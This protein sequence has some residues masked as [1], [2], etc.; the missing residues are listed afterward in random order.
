MRRIFDRVGLVLVLGLLWVILGL[1]VVADAGTVT[2]GRAGCFEGAKVL[3]KRSAHVLGH[4]RRKK[5]H[6]KRVSVAAIRLVR[7]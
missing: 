3:G 2:P 7:L 1:L 4:P 6:L 5:R